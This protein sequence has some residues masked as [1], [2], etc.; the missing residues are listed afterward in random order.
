MDRYIVNVEVVVCKGSQYLVTHRSFAEEVAPG[1]LSFPGG[2]VEK[3][4]SG[5]DVLERTAARELWE[6]TGIAAVNYRYVTSKLFTTPSGK[7]VIDIIFAAEY[8]CGEAVVGAPDELDS[9]F[10]IT[11][12]GLLSLPDL[13]PW[14]R[15]AYKLAIARGSVC[16]CP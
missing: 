8:L 13:P 3:T 4:N 15:E 14:T 1:M 10:W 6:E 5:N 12:E 16:S 7:A 9:V 2:K 11:G